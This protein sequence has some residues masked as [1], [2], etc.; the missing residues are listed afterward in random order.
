MLFIWTRFHFGLN[1]FF[2][3]FAHS[4]CVNAYF[5]CIRKR[6]KKKIFLFGGFVS[7]NIKKFRSFFSA[8]NF[9]IENRIGCTLTAQTQ[10]HIKY[11]MIW[12]TLNNSK[13]LVTQC[14]DFLF[15]VHKKRGE[16]IQELKWISANNLND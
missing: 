16:H 11:L 8:F 14:K 9:S 12:P 6:Y 15:D 13:K 7:S 3:F 10:T 2:F 4:L 1:C 5:F